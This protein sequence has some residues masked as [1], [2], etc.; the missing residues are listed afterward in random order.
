MP[1]V[2]DRVN[3]VLRYTFDFDDGGPAR[4]VNAAQLADL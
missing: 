1:E 4:T 3:A 2:V